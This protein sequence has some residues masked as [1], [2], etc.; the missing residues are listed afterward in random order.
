MTPR[1]KKSGLNHSTYASEKH[2]G[3]PQALHTLKTGK[4][5][6]RLGT[7]AWGRPLGDDPSNHVRFKTD[8]KNFVQNLMTKKLTTFFPCCGTPPEQTGSGL[9]CFFPSPNRRRGALDHS[10]PDFMVDPLH[11]SVQSAAVFS[12]RVRPFVSWAPL[13]TSI[14]VVW[15]VK[16]LS[17]S[18]QRLEVLRG[19]LLTS[20]SH[21]GSG[22]LDDS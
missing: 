8:N 10:F 1:D 4:K 21:S 20:L 7:T 5:A 9:K 15:G 17:A 11:C 22:L 19:I 6:D 14:L 16:P 13:K 12:L 2:R 18:Q 3:R